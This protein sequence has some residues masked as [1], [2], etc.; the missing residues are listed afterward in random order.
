MVSLDE[1]RQPGNLRIFDTISLEV[2]GRIYTKEEIYALIEEIPTALKT[3]TPRDDLEY[4][5]CCVGASLRRNLEYYEQAFGE[6][7]GTIIKGVC[8]VTASGLP[9]AYKALSYPFDKGYNKAEPSSPVHSREYITDICDQINRFGKEHPYDG[10][11]LYAEEELTDIVKK[12]SSLRTEVQGIAVSLYS[13]FEDYLREY[14]KDL[15]GIID[16]TI[17]AARG[18]S[19]LEL[20][21]DRRSLIKPTRSE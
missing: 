7:L 21:F 2:A 3:T 16:D 20:L 18:A 6:D 10:K 14:G 12:I 11:K 8:R 9:A 4:E 13:H 5:L 19:T 17:M 1:F 15:N